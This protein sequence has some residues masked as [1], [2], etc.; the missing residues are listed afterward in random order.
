[1]IESK[2]SEKLNLNAGFGIGFQGL[3]VGTKNTTFLSDT[4]YIS[5]SNYIPASDF[6]TLKEASFTDESIHNGNINFKVLNIYFPILLKYKF[7]DQFFVKAG[8]ELNPIS[9][10]QNPLQEYIIEQNES[11]SKDN[12][13]LKSKQYQEYGSSGGIVTRL[14]VEIDFKI[15]NKIDF[16]IGLTHHVN[17]KFDKSIWSGISTSSNGNLLNSSFRQSFNTIK[18]TNYYFRIMYHL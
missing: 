2:L 12:F 18:A 6:P 5:N 11:N 10:H 16:G 1:M 3:I 15:T 17:N 8:I 13:L 14:N 9:N 4:M 7:D